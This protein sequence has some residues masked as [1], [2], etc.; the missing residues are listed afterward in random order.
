MKKSSSEA[1][2]YTLERS[3]FYVKG[4]KVKA[5]LTELS[6]SSGEDL[7]LARKRFYKQDEYIKFIVGT[8]FDIMTYHKLP[9][10]ST[11]VLQYILYYCIE[12]NDP[13][14]RFKVE[15]FSSITSIGKSTVFRG[16]Q[17]LIDAKY[18]A[19]TKTKEVYWIN[20][21]LFYKGNFM[22]DKH[23]ILK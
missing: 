6:S 3:P 4:W 7:V 1:K 15:D 20:H 10:T 18:I 14:F 17:G 19:K 12:Y 13:V 16:L 23:L 5:S 8:E 2:V 22:I 21:N 9:K 11:T